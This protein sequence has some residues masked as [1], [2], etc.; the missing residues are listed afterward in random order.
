MPHVDKLS[1][2]ELVSIWKGFTEGDSRAAADALERKI[3]EEGQSKLSGPGKIVYL[4]KGNLRFTV[5]TE[6]QRCNEKGILLQE[7]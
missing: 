5:L 1:V 2:S 6:F 3:K 4:H 7:S